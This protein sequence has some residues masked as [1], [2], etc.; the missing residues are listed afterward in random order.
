MCTHMLSKSHGT[1]ST[2][3]R[4][5]Y[6]L[7]CLNLR[8]TASKILYSM[9]STFGA[10]FHPSVTIRVLNIRWSYCVAEQQESIYTVLFTKHIFGAL[11]RKVIKPFW[12]WRLTLQTQGGSKNATHRHFEKLDQQFHLLLSIEKTAAQTHTNWK[13]KHK[14]CSI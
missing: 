8:A 7:T 4:S 14:S 5:Y 10:V 3:C 6:F 1:F 11:K 9:F 12:A 13:W 2:R